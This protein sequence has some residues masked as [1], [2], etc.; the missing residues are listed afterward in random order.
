MIASRRNKLAKPV[1]LAQF[2]SMTAMAAQ[3]GIPYS[4]LVAAKN[5]GC[6]FVRN[7]RADLLVFIRWFFD[8]SANPDHKAKDEDEEEDNTNWA[9]QDKKMSALT[10]EAKLQ[11]LR[12]SQIPWDV[13]ERLVQKLV[14]DIFFGSLE[15]MAQEFPSLMKGRTEVQIAIE[16]E[17]HIERIKEQF[18]SSLSIFAKTK[19]ES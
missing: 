19:G 9:R 11:E 16:L 7:T 3:T 2:S 14:R 1:E 8:H 5:N 10:K 15:R 12:K 18:I 6:P 4:I 17:N 13:C